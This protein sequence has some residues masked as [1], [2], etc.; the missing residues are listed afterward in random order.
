MRWAGHVAV[1]GRRQVHTGV[2]WG[3]IRVRDHLENLG[4][5]GDN[6]KMDIQHV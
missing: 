6:I 2:A 4:I 3:D 5:D 1:W